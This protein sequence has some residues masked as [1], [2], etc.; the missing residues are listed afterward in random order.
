MIKYCFEI[1]VLYGK[2]EKEKIN[3]LYID[4]YKLIY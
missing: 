3:K 4:I 1:T 2:E